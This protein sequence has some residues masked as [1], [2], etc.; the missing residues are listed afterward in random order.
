ME[1]LDDLVVV[2]LADGSGAQERRGV[3]QRR[4]TVSVTESDDVVPSVL[5]AADSVDGTLGVQPAFD[6]ATDRRLSRVLAALGGVACLWCVLTIPTDLLDGK[7][8]NSELA[9]L[10]PAT[11]PPILSIVEADGSTSQGAEVWTRADELIPVPIS[12]DD[13]G[14]FVTGIDGRDYSLVVKGRSDRE[15]S[16]YVNWVDGSNFVRIKSFPGF[17]TWTIESVRSGVTT[18]IGKGMAVTSGAKEVTVDVGSSR[19]VVNVN[20]TACCVADIPATEGSNG[21]TGSVATPPKRY[22]GV[23]GH[24]GST[25]EVN[26]SS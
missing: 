10:M 21:S 19:I 22:A 24:M 4:E 14:A 2:D 3:E 26:L 1:V 6:H 11:R 13:A 20:G 7:S 12:G 9:G 8:R 18:R 17:G 16:L 5:R 15:W 25:T 23:G